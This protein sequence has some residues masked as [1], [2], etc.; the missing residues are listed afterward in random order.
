VS[1][2][3][4]SAVERPTRPSAFVRLVMRPMTRVFNPFLGRLAGGRHMGMA[5]QIHHRGRRSGRLYVTPASARLD[6]GTFWIP[7]TFG[8]GSDWCRNVRAAGGCAIRWKG[9]DYQ[10]TRP[11]VVDRA[12]A[13]SAAHGAFKRRE[14]AMMKMIGIRQFLRMEVVEREPLFR[15]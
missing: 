4:L 6:G 15:P 8:T 11:V 2:T 5:A 9:T 10:A 7:L 12:A 3:A 1:D 13:L 14:R